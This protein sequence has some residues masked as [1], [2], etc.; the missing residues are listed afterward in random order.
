MRIVGRGAMTIKMNIERS[1]LILVWG[2]KW[3]CI[4]Q[5]QLNLALNP[6][7]RWPSRLREI[8]PRVFGK[9]A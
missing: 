3:L 9:M 8:L 6:L 4:A 1:I 7:A 2:K 5:L